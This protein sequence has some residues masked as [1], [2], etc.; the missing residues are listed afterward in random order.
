MRHRGPNN[1]AWIAD[2]LQNA[3]IG[4][5][6]A[7]LSI[8]D[9][10]NSA[11]QPMATR[12]GNL[13][14]VFNGEIYN[15]QKLRNDLKQYGCEFRT[16]SDTEVLL[17]GWQF[18][19]EEILDK[20]IGMF[21]FA[22]YD[23]RSNT[24]T[25]ARDRFGIKPLFYTQDGKHLRFA[26]EVHILKAILPKITKP[27]CQTAYN[28][29]VH[30]EYETGQ[31][32]FFDG[33]Y[34]LP[35]GHI[36]KVQA[37]LSGTIQIA[38]WWHPKICT[39][40]EL[41]IDDAVDLLRNQ[42]LESVK[43][44]LQSDVPIGIALSGGID[45]SAIACA[46]RKIAPEMPINAF[47][48]EAE[49][50]GLNEKRWIDLVC[51]KTNAKKH[52]ISISNG[53]LVNDIDEL[54][55]TQ[56]EPFGSTS[57]YAQYA[58]YRRAKETGIPVILEG[59]G[60]DEVLGGYDGFPG[61]KL[62][63]LLD[64]L[65]IYEAIKFLAKWGD[66]P[67]RNRLEAIKLLIS[68]LTEGRLY[69]LFRSIDSKPSIPEW[70]NHKAI[71]EFGIN[72][73][74][75]H[76]RSPQSYKGKRVLGRLLD[77]LTEKGLQS[78]LRHADRNSMHFSIE[79]RVPFLTQGMMDLMMSLPEEYLISN[80][81]ETKYLFRRAM[82]GIVPPEILNRTDKIGFATPECDWIRNNQSIFQ[83]CLKEDFGLPFVNMKCVREKFEMFLQGKAKFSWQM[84]RF[85]N[86]AKW[87]M[88]CLKK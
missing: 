24:I 88:L 3:V 12:D 28:Y 18:W 6:H 52:S 74:K 41:G 48:Y 58:L 21:A 33:I 78:L 32:T 42:F 7:R 62:H 43:L 17:L 5:G 79:S 1:Q 71:K 47:A 2:R 37:D 29:L 65:K 30:G 38:R 49:S 45:S 67:G 83:N 8:I 40:H 80:Q 25:C 77:L 13:V 75:P 26:S 9:L 20:L 34:R 54:V 73:D 22:V 68:D 61:Q 87:N 66:T 57:I 86:Y 27:N 72:S 16:E 60:G 31:E 23:R 64:N 59:Q 51:S 11:N 56:G 84:W 36:L 44:H 15:Y 82:S 50:R 53:D 76:L 4:L 10:Q 19:G 81:G 85:I 46:I 69:E 70:I 14:I 63:S 35:P 39:N 55:V